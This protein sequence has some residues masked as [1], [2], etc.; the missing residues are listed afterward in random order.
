MSQTIKPGQKLTD[1]FTVTYTRDGRDLTARHRATSDVVVNGTS[2]A[3]S[4]YGRDVDSALLDVLLTIVSNQVLVAGEAVA[5]GE[6]EISTVDDESLARAIR[7][8]RREQARRRKI[9][10]A[11]A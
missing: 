6:R 8:L 1:V 2:V 11:A 5:E 3:C 10:E 9:A 7:L 4:G